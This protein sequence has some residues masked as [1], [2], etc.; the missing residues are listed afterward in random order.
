ML[1]DGGLR[2]STRMGL[3][4]ARPFSRELKDKN[5][6]PCVATFRICTGLCRAG[7]LRKTAKVVWAIKEANER[8]EV[9][10]DPNHQKFRR[11]TTSV[12]ACVIFTLKAQR[13]LWRKRWNDWNRVR[14]NL[15]QHVRGDLEALVRM[16]WPVPSVR[17]TFKVMMT[18]M[19][20]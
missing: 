4:F 11:E 9:Y 6:K 16:S 20:V 17:W 3:L 2:W 8:G 13:P 14:V 19:F 10:Y 12:K 18:N 7:S 15:L 1:R 5:G